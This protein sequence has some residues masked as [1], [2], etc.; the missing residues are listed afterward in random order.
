MG[1]RLTTDAT[2]GPDARAA[3]RDAAAR[4]GR[5]SAG[6]V[7]AATLR[8]TGDLD[9][10][11]EATADAFLLA[12]Q[13]W[14]RTGV[15]RSVD[16]WLITAARNRAVDRIRRA[17]T[18]RRAVITAAGGWSATT[19]GPDA[20]A[21]A[22]LVG[23]DELRMVVLCC[24]P[25]LSVDDRVA[26]TLRLSC[27]VTTDAIA[28][29]FGVPTPTM[30]ARLARARGRFAKAGPRLELPDDRTVD[31]RL[32]A[33]A[34]VVHLAFT[35]GHT[36][37]AG[38]DLTDDALADRAQYLATVL[39]RLRPA[40]PELTAL[41]A[42]I[43]LTRGRAGGRTADDGVQVLL[44]D[45]DRSRWDRALLDQGVVLAD[46]ALADPAAG[47]LTRQAG[48]AAAHARAA[49]WASTDWDAV[50][51]HY[52]ALLTLAPSYTVA[53]G[54]CVAL[55]ERYGAAAGLTDLDE[56]LALGG[57]D[58]YPYAAA[59]RAYLVERTGGDASADWRRA[60]ALARTDAERE[61]FTGR[62]DRRADGPGTPPP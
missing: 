3:A 55:G 47:A 11:E 8:A 26:L 45:A 44:P 42:L 60:A 23:D 53:V 34:V 48:I 32:P 40:D 13:T 14:P 58:S 35:L 27:G 41:L 10:A 4:A 59:A 6:R 52:D 9:I 18:G 39:H 5:E 12:L 57:L 51:T 30:A 61:H 37:A 7:L 62:A 2:P 49:D 36:A 31:E 15:P 28:A 54:R 25:R 24:D 50:L 43:L 21:E 16:A 1:H 33:V 17:R 29:G 22:A 56:V 38:A 19:A 20:I 46:R